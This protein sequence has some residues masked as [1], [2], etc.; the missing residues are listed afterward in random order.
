[1]KTRADRRRSEAKELKK[2]IEI[3]KASRCYNT[4][5]IETI[6]RKT[7]IPHSIDSNYWNPYDT[8]SMKNKKDRLK[9]K[10]EISKLIEEEKV[11]I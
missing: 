6:R 7:D 1:M 2:R 5:G 3:C 8:K 10:S 11:G 4:I 9:Q